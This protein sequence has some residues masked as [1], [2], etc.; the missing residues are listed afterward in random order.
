MGS[1]CKNMKNTQDLKQIQ[2]NSK[3]NKTF[4][5]LNRA[6][7]QHPKQILDFDSSY[8]ICSERNSSQFSKTIGHI[9]TSSCIYMKKRDNKFFTRRVNSSLNHNSLNLLKKDDNN[10][11]SDFSLELIENTQVKLVIPYQVRRSWSKKRVTTKVDL[12]KKVKN[13]KY[14]DRYKRRRT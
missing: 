2:M 11:Q 6:D 10:S 4:K 9:N 8:S 5:K 12:L 13:Q 14:F 1:S 7:F 3:N